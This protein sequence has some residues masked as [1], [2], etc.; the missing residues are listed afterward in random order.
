MAV[1]PRARRPSQT[2]PG[3]QPPPGVANDTGLLGRVGQTTNTP[4]TFDNS[5][6]IREQNIIQPSTSPVDVPGAT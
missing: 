6:A 3:P 4:L 2:T 5:P 1:P